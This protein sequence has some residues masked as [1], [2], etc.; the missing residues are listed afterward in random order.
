MCV[1]FCSTITYIYAPSQP[2]PPY[3]RSHS[4][5]Y[6]V[7]LCVDIV[8]VLNQSLKQSD[9]IFHS[10]GYD[11]YDK[12]LIV[13]KHRIIFIRKMIINTLQYNSKAANC[14][15]NSIESETKEHNESQFSFLMYVDLIRCFIDGR[16]YIIIKLLKY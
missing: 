6:I 7:C 9:Y 5:F 4:F 14:K 12:H 15:D 11:K 16:E 10:S 2:T 1:M 3:R 13:Y 8:N